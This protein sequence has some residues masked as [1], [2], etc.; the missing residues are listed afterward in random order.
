MYSAY[1]FLTLSGL[2]EEKDCQGYQH[3]HHDDV[4]SKILA[5]L[6]HNRIKECIDSGGAVLASYWYRRHQKEYGHCYFIDAREGH[7]YRCVN[8]H[9]GETV[10]WNHCQ[11]LKA[12]K[13]DFVMYLK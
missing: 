4:A 2:F 11:T 10:V 1:V 8:D 7:R 6:I 5:E 3:R 9:P 12:R 13:H